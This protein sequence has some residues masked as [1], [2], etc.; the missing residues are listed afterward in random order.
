MEINK[1][2]SNVDFLI[3][4][5]KES[6]THLKQFLRYLRKFIYR[7]G[8]KINNEDIE[9]LLKSKD[10]TIWQ[11]VL[12]KRVLNTKSFTYKYVTSLN[13]PAKT[14]ILDKIKEK[15]G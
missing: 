4:G 3:Y 15:H 12:L 11:K 13:E 5:A 6:K 14:P 9:E 10:L 2:G 1:E 7:S 8:N